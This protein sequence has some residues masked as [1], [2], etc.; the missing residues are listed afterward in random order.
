[1]AAAQPKEHAATFNQAMIELGATVCLPNGVPKCRECP[2]SAVCLA[3]KSGKETALPIRKKPAPRKKE[4]RTV[5]ILR[6]GDLVALRRRPTEGLLA[7]MYEPHVLSGKLSEGEILAWLAE[8]DVSPLRVIPLGTAKHIFTHLEWHME[9][10]EIIIPENGV[11]L[12]PQD[13]IWAPRE[14]IDAQY[15]L[16][17][18]YAAYRPFM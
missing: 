14:E 12:L 1:V 5:L 13:L 9:G 7:G 10:F 17:S 18:A 15:P 3:H 2:F 8:A 4:L 16:P 11:N 6:C